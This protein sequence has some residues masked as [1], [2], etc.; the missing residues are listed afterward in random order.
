MLRRSMTAFCGGNQPA[1]EEPTIQLGVAPECLG[2]VEDRRVPW[3]APA[4]N[5]KV[6]LNLFSSTRT[7]V[8][9]RT[10][11]VGAAVLGALAMVN[12][13]AARRAERKHPPRG[14]FIE[15]NGV[16]LHYSDRGAGKPVVLVHGNAVTGDDY[17]TS[18]LAE[19][20]LEN[21]RV[22]IFD[23]PGFGHSQRP[24]GRMW[25]AMEQAELLHGALQQLGVERPVVVGHSWGA[26]V[27]L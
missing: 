23:R 1:A 6:A 15:V 8:T 26:I 10:A 17:N 19:R 13:A 12:H 22:I 16:R 20:L 25:T 3:S 18:G 5:R 2:I 4:H 14:R 27:A 24:H 7:R 21:H 11:L 9:G